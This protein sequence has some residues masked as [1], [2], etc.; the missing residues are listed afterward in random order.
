MAGPDRSDR[1]ITPIKKAA[2]LV[3]GGIRFLIPAATCRIRIGKL[4]LA[5]WKNYEYAA[6]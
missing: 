2:P 1:A 6:P 5:G 3:G 4:R